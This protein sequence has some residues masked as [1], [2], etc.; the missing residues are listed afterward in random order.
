MMIW[1]RKGPNIDPGGT[2]RLI[3]G[4]FSSTNVKQIDFFFS[5]KRSTLLKNCQDDLF[6]YFAYSRFFES[7]GVVSGS[8]A[9]C[10]CFVAACTLVLCWQESNITTDLVTLN[11]VW[12]VTQVMFL[13]ALCRS[14]FMFSLSWNVDRVS[15]R[16]LKRWLTL[17]PPFFLQNTP[18]SRVQLN[19][20]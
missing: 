11:L 12:A 18:I 4:D 2:P 20:K 3:A 6:F 5:R 1:N 15:P 10:V 14:L 8:I 9:C 17:P 16:V 19:A 13:P 7:R